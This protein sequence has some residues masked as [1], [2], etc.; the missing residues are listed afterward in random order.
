MT[1]S[2]ALSLA[3]MTAAVATAQAPK[4]DAGRPDIESI[5][6]VAK[7]AGKTLESGGR[8]YHLLAVRVRPG[9]AVGVSGTTGV[10]W[11]LNGRVGTDVFWADGTTPDFAGELGVS[12]VLVWAKLPEKGDVTFV[13]GLAKLRSGEKQ[14]EVAHERMVAAGY[15]PFTIDVKD[16]PVIE[17][18]TAEELSKAVLAL[19]KPKASEPDRDKK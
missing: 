9:T 11:S 17:A 14:E 1:S 18:K 4:P 7:V 10:Y 6:A 2:L 16:I 13:Y 3:A 19:P 12:V 8:T 15:E 5:T